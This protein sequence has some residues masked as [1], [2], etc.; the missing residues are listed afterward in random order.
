[1]SSGVWLSM[2]AAGGVPGPR[3]N[4]H[5]TMSADPRRE[6]RVGLELHGFTVL[7]SGFRAS[8]VI[9]SH[10][11]TYVPIQWGKRRRHLPARGVAEAPR[12]TDQ[13]SQRM[14]VR[15]VLDN[16]LRLITETMPHVRSV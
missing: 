14:V 13:S 16:G 8:L 5:C 3:V 4:S 11:T 7:L 1:M 2:M 12:V 15:D 6:G 10:E 9:P